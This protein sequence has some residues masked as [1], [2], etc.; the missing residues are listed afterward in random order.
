VQQRRR[1]GRVIAAACAGLVLVVTGGSVAVAAF[2]GRATATMAVTTSFSAPTNLKAPC[3]KGSVNVSWTAT[4]RA[5]GYV[6]SLYQNKQLVSTKVIG[7]TT[8]YSFSASGTYTLSLV[9]AYTLQ[10]RSVATW[11]SAPATAT[12][13]C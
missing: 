7:A 12:V 9:A 4:E 3:S 10:G 13:T 2:T 11:T 6:G 1:I 8:S 5:T